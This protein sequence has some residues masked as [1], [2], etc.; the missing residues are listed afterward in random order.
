VDRC[1]KH[2]SI[3]F[4]SPDVGS[5]KYVELVPDVEEASCSK[6]MTPGGDSSA[7]SLGRVRLAWCRC[8]HV[9]HA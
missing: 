7:Y 1:A 3:L 4:P 5:T 9:L 8:E 2:P 6:N